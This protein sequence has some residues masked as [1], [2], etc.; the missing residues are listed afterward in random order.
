MAYGWL[1]G[2]LQTIGHVT[3]EAG[4]DDCGLDAS[5]L[6]DVHHL[7]HEW[8]GLPR[9]G[10]AWFQDDS[11]MWIAGMEVL[12]GFDKQFHIVILTCHQMPTTEINP[13]ELRKPFRELLFNMLQCTCKHIT[14]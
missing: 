3:G 4:I 14:A 6:H 9:K 13:L 5:I 2:H 8:S 10:T 12:Q 11:Q 1:V 7:S